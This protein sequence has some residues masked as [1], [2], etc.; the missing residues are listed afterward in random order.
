MPFTA[1]RINKEKAPRPPEGR[2]RCFGR[3]SPP[4]QRESVPSL[5][6]DPLASPLRLFRPIPQETNENRSQK[7]TARARRS[8]ANSH[9]RLPQSRVGPGHLQH[10]SAS[11]RGEQS[12]IRSLRAGFLAHAGGSG[13]MLP[14]PSSLRPCRA[15]VPRPSRTAPAS[16]LHRIRRTPR[17]TSAPRGARHPVGAGAGLSRGRVGKDAAPSSFPPAPRRRWVVSAPRGARLSGTGLFPRASGQVGEDVSLHCSLRARAAP[18]VPTPITQL[19]GVEGG[20]GRPPQ[21]HWD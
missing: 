7:R 2:S 21:P 9:Q 4:F 16:S 19:P 15:T 17:V 8:Q 3:R 14:C 10:T 1:R 13:R 5:L 18:A 6:V 11:A 20:G 12:G